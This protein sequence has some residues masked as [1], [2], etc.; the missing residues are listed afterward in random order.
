MGLHVYVYA[1]AWACVHV[2][3]SVCVCVC[4]RPFRVYQKG[5]S[6]CL[7]NGT[8][9]LSIEES[10]IDKVM[11]YALSYSSATGVFDKSSAIQNLHKSLLKTSISSPAHISS[12]L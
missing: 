2:C 8:V 6:T 10:I 4:V 1:P 3:V 9:S 12:P 7:N 11:K 5:I